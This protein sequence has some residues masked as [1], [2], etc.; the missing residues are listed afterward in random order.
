MI[1][2]GYGTSL[3][4]L[5]TSAWLHELTLSPG[6]ETKD[7][8]VQDMNVENARVYFDG[9]MCVGTSRHMGDPAWVAPYFS[10]K[11]EQ[12]RRAP[13]V[14]ESGISYYS[15]VLKVVKV[16]VD[17]LLLEKGDIRL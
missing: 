5:R 10:K 16:E 11:C 4:R 9:H 3:P 2:W 14:L 12:S 17:R 7:T 13:E 1:P 15:P 6:D 8:M